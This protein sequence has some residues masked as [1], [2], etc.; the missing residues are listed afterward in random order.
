MLKRKNS[1]P[2]NFKFTWN[3]FINSRTG[4]IKLLERM[5]KEIDM[6]EFLRILLRLNRIFSSKRF[7]SLST[8]C[9][10]FISFTIILD[11]SIVL[12]RRLLRERRIRPTPEISTI[13]EI[14]DWR[15]FMK[16]SVGSIWIKFPF[17]ATNC[18]VYSF[19]LNIKFKSTYHA[20]FGF[21]RL[22]E[23]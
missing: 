15:N 19:R 6:I 18:L 5:L 4:I 3:K 23:W 1:I 14:H 16:D 9:P 13:G 8:T 10:F 7:L 11:L 20:Q 12:A 22:G 17:C 21:N 2:R